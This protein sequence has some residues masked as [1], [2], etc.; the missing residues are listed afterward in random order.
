[1][2]T[3]ATPR[4][5]ATIVVLRES[6]ERSGFEVLLVRRHDKV[7][8]MAGAYV[9]PGGRVDE[10]DIAGNHAPIGEAIARFSDLDSGQED[11]YRRAAAR[12]LAEE[13]GVVLDPSALVPLAHWVT[14]E[15]EPR[16]Y[17]TR[18]FLA[19]MPTDQVARHDERE[20]TDLAWLTADAAVD[21]CRRREIMLPPPTWT[22]LKW[23]AQFGTLPDVFA[24]SARRR[25]PRV[26]PHLVHNDAQTVLTLPGD[27][28]YPAPDG[29]EVPEDTR[30]VLEDGQWRPARH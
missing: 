4:P 21:R 30:F 14:P 19:R 13:A 28:S 11:S 26:Q 16:R 24:A 15:G 29:W 20:T 2:T 7:A 25:I 17:D 8:F 22:T 10:S 3:P 27:P 9:F 23:L 5:A 12:E 18:F 1:V 6:P